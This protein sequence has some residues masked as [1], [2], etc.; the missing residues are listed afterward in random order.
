MDRV[1]ILKIHGARDSFHHRLCR[2]ELG[3]VVQVG[4]DIGCGREITVPQPF[5]YLLQRNRVGQKQRRAGVAEIMEA[6]PGQT[7][8]F[9][10]FERKSSFVLQFLRF[11]AIVS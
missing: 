3:S 2:G 4:V 11:Y 7:V 1:G 9:N 6:H 8:L 10:K 5:L